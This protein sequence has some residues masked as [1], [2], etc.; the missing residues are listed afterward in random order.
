M[1]T[2]SSKSALMVKW[3]FLIVVGGFLVFPIANDL[4]PIITE[5]AP[6]GMPMANP[7]PP[8]SRQAFLKRSWQKVLETRAKR[9][10][11]LWYPLTLLANEIYARGFGQISAFNSGSVRVGLE[12][13]LF[14]T[15]HLSALNH[16]L[17][18]NFNKLS[19]RVADIK[20]L[21]NR[22]K[23]R[24]TSLLIVV[25]PNM[26]HLYPELIPSGYLDPSREKRTHPYDLVEKA[27]EQ[28]GIT[29]VD[30]VDVLK[31]AR[32]KVPF[33]FFAPSASHWNDV[34]SCLGLHAINTKLK[35]MGGRTF[36]AFSCDNYT[37]EPEPRS[38]DRDL[39][40]IANV[41]VPARFHQPTPYVSITYQEPEPPQQP[42]TLLVGTSYLF[43]LSEHLYDW[44]LAKAH[45]LYFYFR[46][47]RSGGEQSFHSLPR[48]SVNW[49]EVFS[50]EIIIVNVGIGNPV[51]IGYGFIEAALTELR[52]RDD[53]RST[54][55]QANSRSPAKS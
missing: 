54:K 16:K 53:A 32:S 39:L 12:N 6:A 48:K 19:Q 25:T 31:E 9:S 29:Y 41:L 21:Q 10:S 24:G 51:T 36:R 28:T 49:D 13:H 38:K 2:I 46:Q 45:K 3:L 7:A 37:V 5:R 18:K 43:A 11:G 35:E 14:Q 40:Q 55:A 44:N 42:T 52:K 17:P 26:A 30:T 22:L 15:A 47:W 27:F 34:A 4:R 1:E 33:R 23:A 50:N 20:E 8:F